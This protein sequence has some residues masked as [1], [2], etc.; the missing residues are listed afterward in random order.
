MPANTV[1]YDNTGL[2]AGQEYCYQM[3]AVNAAGQSTYAG[4]VCNTPTAPDALGFGIGSAY[5]T[6][7]DPAALDLAQFTV[8]TWFKREGTGVTATTGSGGVT[9]AIPLVTKGRGEGDG[10]NVDM[11]YFLGIRASDNVVF[12]D[13]EAMTACGSNPAGQNY[14]VI[15]TTPVSNNVWHHA[16]ATFDGTTW[17]LYLDGNLE[18]TLTVNCQPRSDS[19]QHAGLGTALNSTGV[20]EG[21]FDG[22]LDEVHIW[23]YARTQAEIRST[24][25][26]QITSAQTG[27]VAR[28]A[29][30]DGG[31]TVA[32]S[33][34]T[35]VNGTVTGSGYFW[36]TP[37]APFNV[38][39]A[40]D[41]PTLNAPAIGSTVLT[42]SPTL[43]VN[44]SDPDT[45]NLTVTFYGRALSAM[46]NLTFTLAVLPDTQNY[47]A[48]YPQIFISQTQW[49]VDNRISRNIPYVAHEGDIVNDSNVTTQWTNADTAMDLLDAANVPYGV[50]P[51][52]HDE[53]TNPNNFNAYF[54]VT[55][56]QGK[57]YYGGQY[58]TGDNQNNYALFSAAGLDFIVINLDYTSPAAGSLTWADTLLKTYSARLG[59]VVSH[60]IIG[61]GN[62][63]NF[64][65][66]GSS[67]YT[68]LKSNPNLF[69]MLNGHTHGEG[70]RSDV[71][72][73]HTVHSL[74]AD[75]Q[76]NPN[77]GEG[78]LRLLEFAPA[79]GQIRVRTYSPYLNQFETDANSQFTLT[80]PFTA[81][82]QPIGTVNA[83][84]GSTAN[85]A[86][87]NL[88]N[89]TAYEWYAVTSD[90]QISTTGSINNFTVGDF[91]F[92]DNDDVCAGNE[93]CY[94]TIQAALDHVTSG[95]VTIYDGA[96]NE[97]LTLNK[98]A[99]V[100]IANAAVVNLTGA[101]N[102]NAG[103]FNANNGT[104][105]LTGDFTYSGGTFN[106]GTGSIGFNGGTTQNLN[107]TTPIVF[108]NLAVGTGTTL[109]ETV[110]T[111][112]ATVNG[113]LSNGDTI[114]KIK[115][116]G[117]SGPIGLGLTGLQLNVQT[118]GS[119][120]SL[121]VD[122]IDQDHPS[123]TNN[124]LRTGKYWRITPTG[125]GYNVE[126]T[127]P[128]N[129][130]N[131]PKVCRYTSGAGYDC[132]AD[133]A[134]TASVTRWNVTEFSE[135]TVGSHVGPTAV[136][137][138]ALRAASP[139]QSTAWPWLIACALL[140]GATLA[141]LV[142]WGRRMSQ[143]H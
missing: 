90:G 67:I 92:A 124:N 120:S 126:L 96:Y 61:T 87:P 53:L 26:S 31:T 133:S 13:F 48:T 62:P 108:N 46:P 140:G 7:S 52:N 101:F 32:G 125:G 130:V 78:W 60:D 119:L 54:G 29:L 142:V 100:S 84:S 57:S 103:T 64:S 51:G 10:S 74:L 56:F 37:G 106:A 17:R 16:A 34:G 123:A 117:S 83:T 3:R 77:G 38:N 69:L 116:I 102:M 22:V 27:L 24:I 42:L 91:A 85:L 135:W 88:S 94:P 50:V 58:P 18:T 23:N 63:A 9:N 80:Y 4:P 107:L 118:Q 20:S 2:T 98:N 138:L 12:A 132:A 129:D 71:Y 59:I 19:I 40:P 65:T 141:V 134:T 1:S 15:G 121:Q 114:R 109:I 41:M 66:W 25:N 75:Y 5:V 36:V 136:E 113:S 35:T 115:S 86:W 47:S 137:V 81:G 76:N 93:P 49:I 33:A 73:G 127:L 82:F 95:F 21:H 79:Q 30:N 143:H 111:D 122:R 14:P 112:N 55:R 72:N 99:T 105:N 97:T 70:Q 11:N 139:D 104:L 6:F 43:S 131:D 89:N 110:S 68:A 128:H 28:W 39:F 44:V 45:T 8:E